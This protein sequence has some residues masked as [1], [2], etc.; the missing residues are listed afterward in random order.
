LTAYG[1]DVP[2]DLLDRIDE[3]VPSPRQ[4]GR[5][6]AVLSLCRASDTNSF[7]AIAIFRP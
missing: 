1:I 2:A 7:S 6:G 4:P 5:P 3:M